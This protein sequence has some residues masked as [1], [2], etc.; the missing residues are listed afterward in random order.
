V[1]AQAA[2]ARKQVAARVAEQAAA[3]AERRAAQ[4]TLYA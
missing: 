2:L 3:E 4:A 1:E